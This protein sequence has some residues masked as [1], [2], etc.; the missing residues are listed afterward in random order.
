V[1]ANIIA[2]ASMAMMR[3]HSNVPGEFDFM[4]DWLLE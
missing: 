2:K 4:G 3:I 1:S